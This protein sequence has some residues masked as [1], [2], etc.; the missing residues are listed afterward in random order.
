MTSTSPLERWTSPLA[1]TSA[2][3]SVG[4]RAPDWP[5]AAVRPA[6]ATSFLLLPSPA[7]TGTLSTSRTRRKTSRSPAH[8][9]QD[10]RVTHAGR[11]RGDPP[12]EPIIHSKVAHELELVHGEPRR[13]RRA[14][15]THARPRRHPRRRG[16]GGSVPRARCSDHRCATR[17]T[18]AAASAP[19]A[20]CA[21]AAGPRV[22]RPREQATARHVDQLFWPRIE[23][24]QSRLAVRLQPRAERAKKPPPAPRPLP[25]AGSVKRFL[26]QQQH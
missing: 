16:G 7:P 19:S 13:V 21:R 17:P 1:W 24:A 14:Q 2:H 20:R 3:G 6:S 26:E 25:R 11:R 23:R 10:L 4:R 15:P 8:K 22:A 18:R 5:A 9:Q 12:H